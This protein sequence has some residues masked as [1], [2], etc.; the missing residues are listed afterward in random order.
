MRQP[1]QNLCDTRKLGPLRQNRAV[2]HQHGQA[3]GTRHVQL[4][5]RA[6]AACVF[7]HNQLRAVAQHQRAVLRF[8]K[9]STGND[10]FGIRQGQAFGVVYKAQ[11]V[12]VLGLGGKVFKMHTTNGEEHA[13][14][15]AGQRVDG[16]CNVRDVMPGVAG[17]QRPRRAGQSGQRR[18]R[19]PTRLNR[20]PAHLG[21][22]RV[23]R[24]HNMGNGVFADVLGQTFRTAEASNA[25]WQRLRAW[26][27]HTSGVGIHSRNP[28]F[29]NGF[30]QSVGLGR[31]AKDQHIGDQEVGHV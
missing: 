4:G 30:G 23:G 11:Q 16:R 8:G 17:L 14:G 20:V 22:K 5:P 12:M 2:D 29:R 6:R 27:F 26:A 13:L 9:W 28:L 24:I 21:R 19:C 3:Q 10:N 18:L 15:V 25:H 1:V 7:G 31:T